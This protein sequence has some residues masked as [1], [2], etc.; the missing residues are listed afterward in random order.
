MKIKQIV[1]ADYIEIEELVRIHYNIKDYEFAF[2]QECGNDS[3]HFF[4]VNGIIDKYDE[5]TAKKIRNGFVPEYSNDVLLNLLCADSH[6]EKGEY[7][8][9]VSW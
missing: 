5:N 9:K 7:F 2:V 4:Q 8:I 6:I 1:E 3:V